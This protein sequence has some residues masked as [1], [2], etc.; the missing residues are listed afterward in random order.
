MGQVWIIYICIDCFETV[1][2]KSKNKDWNRKK[3]SFKKPSDLFKRTIS[4]VLKTP[5]G[6]T[7]TPGFLLE[8]VLYRNQQKKIKVTAK[9]PSHILIN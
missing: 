3:E 9:W 1:M 5:Y 2:T 6:P 8:V 7:V 4:L